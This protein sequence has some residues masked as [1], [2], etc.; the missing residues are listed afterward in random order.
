M[1]K[2][3]PLVVLH[4]ILLSVHQWNITEARAVHHDRVKR[5]NLSSEERQYLEGLYN[6]FFEVFDDH[7]RANDRSKQFAIAT[8]NRPTDLNPCPLVMNNDLGEISPTKNNYLAYTPVTTPDGRIHSEISILNHYNVITKDVD[9]QRVHLVTH[10]SPCQSCTDG[11][12]ALVTNHRSTTFYIGYVEQYQNEDNLNYFIDKVG[13]EDN[14]CSDKYHLPSFH[15]LPV[16]V[17][18]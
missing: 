4:F 11:L 8:I 12:R 16:M 6:D 5:A 2:R 10:F 9:V 7:Y 13:N 3:T 14:V 17:V 15:P 18:G 1:R